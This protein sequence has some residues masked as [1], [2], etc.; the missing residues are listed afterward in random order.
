GHSWTSVFAHG[1][2]TCGVTASGAAYC[3]GRNNWGQLG[4]AAGEASNQRIPVQG[5]ESF[6]YVVPGDFHTCGVTATGQA[7]C[8]GYRGYGQLGT[9][10]TAYHGT[11]APVAGGHAFA[12]VDPGTAH[13]C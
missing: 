3:W 13:T 10:N 4:S 12:Q 9:G 5:G 2:V 7:R 6:N 8:W 11:P 1:Q